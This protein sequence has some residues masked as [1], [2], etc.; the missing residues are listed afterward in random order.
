[1]RVPRNPGVRRPRSRSHPLTPNVPN[2]PV[3][4]DITV[5]PPPLKNRA[6]D[7]VPLPRMPVQ[8]ADWKTDDQTP[9]QNFP[10]T[11]SNLICPIHTLPPLRPFPHLYSFIF[12]VPPM[13]FLNLLIYTLRP[14]HHPLSPGFVV[15]ATMRNSA[16]VP[17]T[18]IPLQC[19]SV[20]RLQLVTIGGAI[21]TGEAT[22]ERRGQADACGLG[23]GVCLFGAGSFVGF[24][25]GV[26]CREEAF[27]EQG[28]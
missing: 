13:T 19:L 26:A 8:Q 17:A 16:T 14:I 15:V 27:A 25:A 28:A 10:S 5:L 12:L 3:Q 22:L 1:M 18:S 11:S 23:G 20:T 9:S 7:R 2:R 24:R 21:E 6:T 4:K